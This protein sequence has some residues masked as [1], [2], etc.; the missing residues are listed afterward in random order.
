MHSFIELADYSG[1]FESTFKRARFVCALFIRDRSWIM[2][3]TKKKKS[4]HFS[5]NSSASSNRRKRKRNLLHKKI[6]WRHRS[7][8]LRE[9]SFTDES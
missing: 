2:F 7:L 3:S 4:S 6:L 1:K 5:R 8:V 9:F